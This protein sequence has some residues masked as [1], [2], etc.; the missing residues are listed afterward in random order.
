MSNQAGVQWR[1]EQC[2]TLVAVK[3][4][5]G[6]ASLF[7]CQSNDEDVEVEGGSHACDS[8]KVEGRSIGVDQHGLRDGWMSCM[9]Q[10]QKTVCGGGIWSD[11]VGFGQWLADRW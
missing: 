9:S 10:L 1:V 11:D 7:L 4:V 8:F 6:Q 3:T 5:G 2:D